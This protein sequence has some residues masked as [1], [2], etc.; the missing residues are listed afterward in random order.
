MKTFLDRAAMQHHPLRV[1]ETFL[2]QE[3][4]HEQA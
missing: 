1:L 4:A 3:Q 2:E